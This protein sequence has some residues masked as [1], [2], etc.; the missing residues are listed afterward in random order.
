MKT[1][2]SS[3]GNTALSLKKAWSLLEDVGAEG[4][5]CELWWLE[6]RSERRKGKESSNKQWVC[7][8]TYLVMGGTWEVM[9]G[10]VC[11]CACVCVSKLAAA[12]CSLLPSPRVSCIW[13]HASANTTSAG[14]L[15]PNISTSLKQMCMSEQMLEGKWLCPHPWL[16]K[17]L[18][19][20]ALWAS[21]FSMEEG[22]VS[23]AKGQRQHCTDPYFLG[24]D[25]S[26]LESEW[27]SFSHVWLFA[28]PWTIQSMEFSRHR[29]LEWVAF[30]FSRGS[31]QP[32]DQTQV[33]LI[34]VRFFTS[35]A[36]REAQEYWSG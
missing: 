16:H 7:F 9:E 33:S 12:G 14:L 30:P 35:W 6:G 2:T 26:L 15:F 31:S 25:Y 24:G 21:V 22:L 4:S 19:A 32:R 20:L 23:R 34:A 28:T 36:T 27:K 17:D 10:C 1:D 5:S 8:V 18:R 29:I 13:N 11:L 3:A